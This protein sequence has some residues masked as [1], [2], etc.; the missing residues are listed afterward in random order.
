VSRQSPLNFGNGFLFLAPPTL[1]QPPTSMSDPETKRI[2]R[3]DL[4]PALPPTADKTPIHLDLEFIPAPAPAPDEDAETNLELDFPMFSG[5]TLQRITLRSP[6]PPPPEKDVWDAFAR[7]QKRPLSHWILAASTVAQRRAE[8]ASVLV[9]GEE[10]VRCAGKLPVSNA[11]RCEWK[12]IHA[13]AKDT[14]VAREGGARKNPG[15]K[16]RVQIRVAKRR[17]V[18]REEARLK[19]QMGRD[20]FRGLV[21]EARERAETEERVR[22]NREKKL[23]RRLKEKEKK[24]AARGGDVD[25][26]NGGA[27]ALAGLSG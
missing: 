9:T 26:G 5:P 3:T 10:V 19:S 21:G 7:A 1:S 22:K 27:S 20:R 6:T 12:V 16:R 2:S 25:G 15:K 4:S 13:P 11:A 18:E 24:A 8:F 14:G 17:E 23:K